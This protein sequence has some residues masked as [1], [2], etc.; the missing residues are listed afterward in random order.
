MSSDEK[1]ISPTIATIILAAITFCM[2]ALIAWMI[3]GMRSG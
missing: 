2:A 1:G 3:Y